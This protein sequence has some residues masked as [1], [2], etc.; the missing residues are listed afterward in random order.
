MIQ[1]VGSGQASGPATPAPRHAP[2][3]LRRVLLAG[4]T[5]PLRAGSRLIEKAENTTLAPARWQAVFPSCPI[6]LAM[7][8]LRL[9]PT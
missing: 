6:E 3:L 1:F 7:R 8:K 4:L 9:R 2:P 5:L